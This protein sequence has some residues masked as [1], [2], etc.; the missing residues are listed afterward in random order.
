MRRKRFSQFLKAWLFPLRHINDA[1][2]APGALA[3]RPFLASCRYR[4]CDL[5][6]CLWLVDEPVVH[7]W[8]TR[9]ASPSRPLRA[10][11]SYAEVGVDR[12]V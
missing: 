4:R 9:R 10:V 6:G 3:D 12:D 1:A 11:A 7:R 8:L 2:M 5:Q